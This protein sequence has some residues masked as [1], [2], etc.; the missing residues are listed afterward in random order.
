MQ[1]NW[2]CVR[3]ILFGVEQLGDTC[4]ILQAH[5]VSGFDAATVSY[6]MQLLIDAG[7]VR[8]T[9]SH[10]INA[11]MACM[12][13]SLTWEGHEFLDR[14]RS[15]GAWNKVKTVAREKGVALSFDVIKT[16][17]QH[18]VTALLDGK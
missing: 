11:P 5:D 4:S 8:G 15:S 7:L 16:I 18:M 13:T 3:A 12:V 1:R 14:T 10:Y 9:C 2:E 17:A 6:H